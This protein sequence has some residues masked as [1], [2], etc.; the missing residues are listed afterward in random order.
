MLLVPAMTLVVATESETVVEITVEV[1]EA[2]GNLEEQKLSAAG[3]PES[4][5][6]ALYG[7]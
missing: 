2:S 5:R 6:R 4:T 3:T 1:Q 7:S